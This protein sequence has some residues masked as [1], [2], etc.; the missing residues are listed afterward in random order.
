MLLKE[1]T[2]AGACRRCDT[3][4]GKA[5]HDLTKNRGVVLRLRAPKRFFDAEI[6]QRF[7]HALERASIEGFYQIK[8]GR[9]ELSPN[10]ANRT[11]NSLAAF[12]SLT[13]V[14]A[15]ARAACAAP[16]RLASPRRSAKR[17]RSAESGLR[18]SKVAKSAY[19]RARARSIS[20]MLSVRDSREA[21][22][23]MVFNSPYDKCELRPRS[24]V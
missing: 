4:A 8:Y 20:S 12:C 23:C 24:F 1:L 6:L 17:E 18:E 19:S 13:R 10:P 7:P 11:K 16:I 2:L 9:G 22:S 15:S 5:C 14:A 21:D 3:A